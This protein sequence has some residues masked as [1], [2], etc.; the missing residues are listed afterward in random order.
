[1]ESISRLTSIPI[2][3]FGLEK[4]G[5]V[6]TTFKESNLLFHWGLENAESRAMSVIDTLLPAAKIIEKPLTKLDQIMCKSLDLVEDHIPYYYF[7]P[8]QLI[9]WNTKEYVSDKVIKPVLDKGSYKN[10]GNVVLESKAAEF[11]NDFVEKCDEYVEKYLPDMTD[12]DSRDT[13]DGV[14]PSDNND[15]YTKAEET[16]AVETFRRGRRL[17]KKLKRRLTQ[18]TFAEVNALRTG[19][20]EAVH[21]LVYGVELIITDPR[22]AAEKAKELWIYL[23]GPEPGNQER[24]KNIEELMVILAR[25][26]CR[27]IVHILNS[28]FQIAGKV[29]KYYLYLCKFK[30][31][32]Y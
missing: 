8:P 21:I 11:Y 10:L 23:S 25:E 30:N 12:I 26:S 1:M 17:S 18:R 2:I 16:H 29:P 9:Y 24:P 32:T 6:Y 4:A 19:G 7:L 27:T 20:A 5:H 14:K 31:D 3:S 15:T 28:G 13:V 22:Q